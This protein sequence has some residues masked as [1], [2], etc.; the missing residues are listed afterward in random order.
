MTDIPPPLH[1]QITNAT[2]EE[3]QRKATPMVLGGVFCACA[4]AVV[5]HVLRGR[6]I[7]VSHEVGVTRIAISSGLFGPL[8]ARLIERFPERFGLSRLPPPD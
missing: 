7:S 5:L 2:D 1:R 6:G 4:A 8:V 3:S